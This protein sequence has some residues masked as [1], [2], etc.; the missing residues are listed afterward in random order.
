M[1]LR[2]VFMG[3]PEFSVVTLNAIANAGHNIVAAFSQPPRPRGKR[4]LELQP[5]PVHKAADLRGI[6]VLTPASLKGAAEQQ[7]FASLKADVAVVVAYGLLLPQ[8]VLAT[9]RFGCLNGHASKLPRWRGA[10]PIQRAI[11]AG[12][13]ETAV[14]IMRMEE[15]LD[16]GPV[17]LAAP[18]AITPSTTAG[19]LHDT[20]AVRGAAL[21]VEALSLLESGALKETPQSADGVTYAAKI[22]KSEAQIDFARPAREVLAHIHGLSPAPGAWFEAA[23][24]GG[25]PERI[26]VLR[27]AIGQGNGT[28]GLFLNGGAEIACAV[29]SIQLI[30][31]LRSGKKPMPASEFLRGFP[32]AEGASV[33]RSPKN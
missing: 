27:A 23:P 33:V 26:K 12:D 25:A 24:A 6:P 3:T 11:M 1:T 21:M 10:A 17:C 30:E 14:M 4:G 7:Q 32:L 31:V 2:V 20:L 28:L 8:A 9:P 5:S 22:C 29:G 13:T 15:G 18:V 19:T 16:T